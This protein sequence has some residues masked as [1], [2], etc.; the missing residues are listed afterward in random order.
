MDDGFDGG[1]EVA[2]AAVVQELGMEEMTMN[3]GGKTLEQLVHD[4]I[5]PTL[6]DYL[7]KNLPSLVE[8]ILAEEIS[9][10]VKDKF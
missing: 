4:M 8:K 9:K 7:E 6:Q 10:I 3:S 2:S 1:A 5:K